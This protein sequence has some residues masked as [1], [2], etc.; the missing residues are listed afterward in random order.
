VRHL[1]ERVVARLREAGIADA[2]SEAR[3]IVAAAEDQP[4]DGVEARTL[5]LC[6][7]RA[8]G[9]PLAFAIGRTS[10]MGVE[11]IVAPGTLV[12]REETRLLG[13]TALHL[14]N[15]SG[16]AAPRLIDMCC[17]G[18][19]LACAL[20]HYVPGAHVWASD[21]TDDSVALT[22]RN[23]HELGL[24]SR[25][26]VSQGDLFVGLAGLGLEDSIDMVVCNPPYI[27]SKRLA[28]G[29]AQLLEHEPREAFD[30]GPYGLSIHQRVAKE[31][32]AFL[33]PGGRLLFEIGLGQERQLKAL[34]DRSHG[35][36]RV[37][38]TTDATGV[39]R[40]VSGRRSA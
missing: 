28:E 5:E 19:N 6:E 24:E 22:R 2:E 7:A 14:L 1:L 11:L 32:L 15:S 29:G 36:D 30:G 10:F 23:V 25:V 33:R 20:A 16:L 3:R 26:H 35:Y 31:C 17:G 27:S 18:G 40:I 9:I 34:F 12:P 4:G 8:K 13:E 38:F 37:E 39:T 21:L